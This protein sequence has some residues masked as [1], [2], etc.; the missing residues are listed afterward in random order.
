MPAR[1]FGVDVSARWFDVACGTEVRRFAN[2]PSGIA[3]FIGGI[4]S[5]LKIPCRKSLNT[6]TSAGVARSAS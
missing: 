2:T 1:T 3:A 4:V 5:R 6:T